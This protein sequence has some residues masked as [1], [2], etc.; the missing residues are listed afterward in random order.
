[1]YTKQ[2]LIKHGKKEVHKQWEMN[3]QSHTSQKLIGQA[4]KICSDTDLNNMISNELKL[5]NTYRLL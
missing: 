5:V 2:Q 4:N 1:M 3:N